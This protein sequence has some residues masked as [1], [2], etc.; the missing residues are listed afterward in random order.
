LSSTELR[1]DIDTRLEEGG[2]LNVER[3]WLK[4]CGEEKAKGAFHP[5]CRSERRTISSF[6]SLHFFFLYGFFFFFLEKR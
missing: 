2:E 4:E 5:K 1:G 3:M 6:L